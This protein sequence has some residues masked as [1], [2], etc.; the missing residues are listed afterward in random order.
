MDSIVAL[1][2]SMGFT[3]QYVSINTSVVKSGCACSW[4]FTF[5]YVSI[6]TN[7]PFFV[8]SIAQVFTFQYVSIN[9]S[10]LLH[11]GHR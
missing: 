9:T 5:Q 8:C 6:N 4:A 10:V 1:I 2:E 11:K 7:H 3:F